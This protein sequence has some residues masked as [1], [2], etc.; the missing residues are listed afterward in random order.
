MPI[1]AI[2]LAPSQPWCVRSGYLASYRWRVGA[3]PDD[4]ITGNGALI[5]RMSST[6]FAKT[7]G[8]VAGRHDLPLFCASLLKQEPTNLE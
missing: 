4:P 1:T 2:A 8:F 5:T 6:S 7:L 3:R